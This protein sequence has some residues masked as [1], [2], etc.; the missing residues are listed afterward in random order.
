M[1]STALER[2]ELG[3]AGPAGSV[4]V[5]WTADLVLEADL[6]VPGRMVGAF[7]APDAMSRV[8]PLVGAEAPAGA[9]HAAW[10]AVVLSAVDVVMG[11]RPTSFEPT[12]DI[13]A[14]AVGRVRVVLRDGLPLAEGLV[15]G[16]PVVVVD[17]ERLVATVS[18][19]PGPNRTR[20]SR[21]GPGRTEGSSGCSQR[22]CAR[23]ARCSPPSCTSPGTSR[24]S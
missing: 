5:A 19:V 1:S 13:G 2:R 18:V 20:R 9:R 11:H 24:G 17:P 7:G 15:A 23:A 22:S 14:A 3:I 16:D 10:A 8:R 6:L 12:A 21:S 4:L